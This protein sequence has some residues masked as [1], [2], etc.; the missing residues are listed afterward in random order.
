MTRTLHPSPALA[1][2]AALLLSGTSAARDTL[3]GPARV[4][5]GDTLEVQGRRVR[6]HGIDAPEGAQTCLDAAGRPWRCGRAATD[7]LAALIG[8]GS[9]TCRVRGTDRW[10][11]AVAVCRHDGADLNAWM[12][13]NGHALAYRRYGQDYAAHEDAAR[14]ARLGVWQG[15]F[16]APWD[17]RRARR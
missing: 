1:L 12:V 4:I 17:W 13:S 7:A 16:M 15:R 2:L 6:L 11:R 5:D 14:G 10:G 8:R 3:T 9:V